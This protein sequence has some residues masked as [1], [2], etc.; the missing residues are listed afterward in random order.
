MQRKELFLIFPSVVHHFDGC[1]CKF[2]SFLESH[3]FFCLLVVV[4]GEQ[5]EDDGDVSLCVEFGESL[6]DALADIVKVRRVTFDDASDGDDAVDVSEFG[7]LRC[8]IDEFKTSGDSV[9]GDVLL[10]HSV[11]HEFADS[12]FEQGVG[13]VVVPFGDDDAEAH[14]VGIGNGSGLVLSVGEG[15]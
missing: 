9:D 7:E 1:D 15:A 3:S 8:S 6:C 11:C 10:C 2:L 5:S 4:D 13:D 12:L 14:L